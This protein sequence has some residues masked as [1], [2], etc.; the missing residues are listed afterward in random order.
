MNRL[1]NTQVKVGII[2]ICLILT[3]MLF[4]PASSRRAEQSNPE[5]IG[6][7]LVYLP[8][9]R[10]PFPFTMSR[11]SV[12]SDGT[13]GNNS[14]R[15][16]SIS[17]DGRYV[18]FTS[19]ANNLV[20][21]DTNF[22]EDIFVHD[23]QTGQ[24]RRVSVATDGTQG[25]GSSIRPSIST[26][27]RYVAFISDAD[28]LVSGDTNNQWD[29][30]VHDRQ[31][32]E[33]HRIS[34]STNG[35]QSNGHSGGP[36]I[37]ADG[38]YVAFA[39][40]AS[41]LVSGDTNGTWDVFVHDRQTRQTTRVS[42]ASN[43][44]QG[45]ASSSR[46]SISADGRYVAFDSDANNLVSGDTNYYSDVFVH[47]RQTGQTI[48]V[49]VASDGTQGHHWSQ[50]VF[51]SI[52]GRYVAFTSNSNNLVSGDT[53][54]EEDVFIHDL[55]T[56]ETSRVSVGSDGAQGDGES[57]DPFI[58]ANS[59]YVVFDSSSNNWMPF[60]HFRSIF[61]HDRQTGEISVVSVNSQGIPSRGQ[62]A[63]ASISADGRYTTFMSYASDLVNGDTNDFEDVF[64]YDRGH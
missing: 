5:G 48:R 9:L 14:S 28:N 51:I 40:Q 56:G 61:V 26:D 15:M 62:S 63:E 16:P 19:F 25:N 18:A 59:R 3:G 21:G 52:D 58:S 8:V 44:T 46:H 4:Q 36:A 13:E 7:S 54:H 41:N 24:I 11:I 64:V 53:N 2:L 30:F 22:L 17:A 39:S 37:S 34:V 50:Q 6:N 47:D 31:T 55:Q 23:R 45:N 27:G 57:R 42:V 12:A 43:G 1:K 49:S 33:N 29:V 32:G 60:Q 38:R 35:T 10:R 20:S